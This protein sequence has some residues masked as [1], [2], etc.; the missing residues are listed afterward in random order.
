MRSSTSYRAGRG[1]ETVTISLKARKVLIIALVYASVPFIAIAA[2]MASPT[3]AAR[4]ALTHDFLRLWLYTSLCVTSGGVAC[5]L[6]TLLRTVSIWATAAAL[7]VAVGVMASYLRHPWPS[8]LLMGVAVCAVGGLAA[9]LIVPGLRPYLRRYGG[10]TER[11][12][13]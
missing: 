6:G 1:A 11:H 10:S 7:A 3:G 8:D 2:C 5:A 9:A 13:G 12:T 4:A